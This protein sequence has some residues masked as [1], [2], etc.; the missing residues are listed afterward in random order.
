MPNLPILLFFI[1]QKIVRFCQ[2]PNIFYTRIQ[3]SHIFVRHVS[4]KTY[5][6]VLN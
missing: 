5:N 1:P 4:F 6:I 2:V 3:L